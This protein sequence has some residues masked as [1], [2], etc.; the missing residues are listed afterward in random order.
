MG[1]KILRTRPAGMLVGGDWGEGWQYGPLSVV[2]Y[3]AAARA[4]E[5]AGAAM[6]EM[7]A[8]A[9]SL[10]V[11]FMHGSVPTLDGMFNSN[12]DLDSEEVYPAASANPAAEKGVTM[13]RRKLLRSAAGSAMAV[14]MAI[15]LPLS[16]APV[17][18]GA[19]ETFTLSSGDLNHDSPS[20]KDYTINV[21][22]DDKN[23]IALGS[24]GF[25]K[26]DLQAN[27]GFKGPLPTAFPFASADVQ[28]GT[29]TVS[30]IL[31]HYRDLYTPAPGSPLI[32]AG[33]PAGNPK[34]NIGA[35]GQGSDMDPSDQFGTVRPGSGGPPP[36]E[37]RPDRLHGARASAR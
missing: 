22:P 2:E 35:I 1:G 29:V 33:H 23:P 10:V 31:T 11:R 19:G 25:G 14:A 6:P 27:P 36:L 20:Q 15:A 13:G 34:N 32:G 4:M 12:G 28:A 8:W 37:A 16:A 26:H 30:A 17:S 3:A 5:E 9:S 18:I 24:D 7:D 21:E